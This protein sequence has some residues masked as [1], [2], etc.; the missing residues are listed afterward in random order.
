MRHDFLPKP[1]A[2]ESNGHRINVA[3]SGFPYQRRACFSLILQ[4][5]RGKTPRDEVAR[6][7]AKR[8]PRSYA[9]SGVDAS[10]IRRLESNPAHPFT[11]QEEVT[12]ICEA[13]G[14]DFEDVRA[15]VFAA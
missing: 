2:N 9:G 4:S 10:L 13:L 5:A 8:L 1:C 15:R 6:R 11:R 7:A 3:M 12:A 14:L